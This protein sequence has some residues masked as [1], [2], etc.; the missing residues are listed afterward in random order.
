MALV[1]TLAAALALGAAACTRSAQSPPPSQ[2]D[3]R[4]ANEA[5]ATWQAKHE[6]DYRRDWVS[7]AS[8]YDLKAGV[9]TAGRASTNY[10]VLPASVPP[11]LGR[12][13]MKGQQVR[14]EPAP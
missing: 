11:T 1:V 9:N 3:Q 2:A 5:A 6:V 4:A 13:I 14:F 8:L 12:F 10:I 7:I